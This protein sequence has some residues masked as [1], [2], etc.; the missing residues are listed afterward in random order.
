MTKRENFL[1][2][3]LMAVTIEAGHYWWPEREVFFHFT[4]LLLLIIGFNLWMVSELL[5]F[6]RLLRHMSDW[7]NQPDIKHTLDETSA[8]AMNQLTPVNFR[9]AVKRDAAIVTGKNL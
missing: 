5:Y 9:Q 3:V 2:L 4:V 7:R 6:E 8:E 1:L